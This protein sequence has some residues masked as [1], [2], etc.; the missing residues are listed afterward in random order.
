MRR[1]PEPVAGAMSK[2][3]SPSGTTSISPASEFSSVPVTPSTV[4]SVPGVR[5]SKV[6]ALESSF[7]VWWMFVAAR[8]LAY[9]MPL[10]VAI[11]R[12]W[13][14]ARTDRILPVRPYLLTNPQLV[15]VGL[16]RFVGGGVG[17]GGGRGPGVGRQ[18]GQIP[19]AHGAQDLVAGDAIGVLR[20]G[21]PT[22]VDT[23]VNLLGGE[24]RRGQFNGVMGE[25]DLGLARC[26]AAVFAP[27]GLHLVGVGLARLGG[28]GV[29]VGGGGGP[30]VGRQGG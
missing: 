8:T 16:S 19:F 29:G 10:G 13:S 21:G 6:R 30:G 9:R 5:S 12:V 26:L 17:V 18:G 4:T 25:L 3:P 22:Q 24:V 7:V 15:G 14:S 28:G 23:A 20:R 27:D 11:S 2:P 1:G